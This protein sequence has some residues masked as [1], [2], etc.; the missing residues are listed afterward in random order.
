MKTQ[1]IKVSIA[2]LISAGAIAGGLLMTSPQPAAA[3][4][5]AARSEPIHTQLDG[6]LLPCSESPVGFCAIG[7]VTSGVLKGSK[8]A[9]YQ[10]V[11][12]S[13]GMPNSE[14]ASTF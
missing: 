3:Q 10:A 9:I 5:A 6:W 12:L 7:T 13:A 14:P 8:E 1:R 11:S 2:R 4:A